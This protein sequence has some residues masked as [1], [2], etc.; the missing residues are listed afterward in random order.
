MAKRPEKV[1]TKKMDETKRIIKGSELKVRDFV[2]F[3]HIV[4]RSG[5]GAHKSKKTYSRNAKHKRDDVSFFT[6]L[7]EDAII[8]SIKP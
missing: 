7:M 2:H 4:H 1:V 3:D 6:N 5:T 8:A